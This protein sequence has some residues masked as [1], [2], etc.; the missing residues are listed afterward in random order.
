MSRT[1]GN[2]HPER[3]EGSTLTQEL[4]AHITAARRRSQPAFGAAAA[5]PCAAWL[6]SPNLSSARFT[7]SGKA[8]VPLQKLHD[9]RRFMPSS[10]ALQALLANLVYILRVARPPRQSAPP[11]NGRS[12][13]AMRHNHGEVPSTI[14]DAAHSCAAASSPSQYAPTG[15]GRCRSRSGGRFGKVHSLQ[16]VQRPAQKKRSSSPST[17]STGQNP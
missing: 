4:A 11:E 17:A 1:L 2:C 8:R 7:L 13:R 10:A 12:P 14:A 16:P 3:S 9:E 15:S 6:V 5:L